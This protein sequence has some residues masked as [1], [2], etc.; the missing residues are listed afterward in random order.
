MHDVIFE[1]QRALDR[2][3]LEQYAKRIGLDLK[4]FRRELDEGVWTEKVRED[5]MSGV[6]SG[7]NGTPTFFING[8]RHDGGY[9]LEELLEAATE[10]AR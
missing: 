1:N 2:A 8:R 6:R 3:S 5:F 7:V 9:S 10:A 4:R